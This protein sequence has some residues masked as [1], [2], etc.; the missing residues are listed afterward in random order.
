[1]SALA[2]RGPDASWPARQIRRPDVARLCAPFRWQARAPRCAT[3][4]QPQVTQR[5]PSDLQP[6]ADR[7][8]PDLLPTP[9][10][11]RVLS[12]WGAV[13]V[14]TVQPLPELVEESLDRGKIDRRDRPGR[15][16][17]A[18]VP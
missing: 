1:M 11:R 8:F 2:P 12:P 16:P 14:A 4:P 7:A 9:R 10:T 3:N 17:A 15:A 18:G 6:K 13:R 5:R